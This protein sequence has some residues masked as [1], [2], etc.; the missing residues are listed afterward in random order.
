MTNICALS[1]S[2]TDSPT[3]WQMNQYIRTQAIYN[4]DQISALGHTH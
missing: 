2:N 1:Y 4:K 3:F